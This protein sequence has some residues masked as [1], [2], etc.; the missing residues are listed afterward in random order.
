MINHAY[1]LLPAHSELWI[2]SPDTALA[3]PVAAIGVTLQ[4][5]AV[6][7]GWLGATKLP[8]KNEAPKSALLS[9]FED[10]I[11]LCLVSAVSMRTDNPN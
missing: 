4:H 9:K 3:A 1:L 6:S 2:P 10:N 8:L 7:K 11:V 5:G